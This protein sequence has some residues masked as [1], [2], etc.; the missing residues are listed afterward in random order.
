MPGNL[1]NWVCCRGIMEWN[2][3]AVLLCGRAVWVHPYRPKNK[4]EPGSLDSNFG[5]YLYLPLLDTV[6]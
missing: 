4:R 6:V 2:Y 3:T 5:V 1:L